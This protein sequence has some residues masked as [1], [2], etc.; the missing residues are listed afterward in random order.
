MS[1]WNI[2]RARAAYNI[3]H[4]GD[5]YFD[6]G[7]DGHA[8]ARPR[9]D[10]TQPAVDLHRLAG[11][12]RR[13]GLDLPVLVRFTDILGDRVQR[14]HGAFASA[15]AEHGYAGRYSPAYPIKTNQRRRVIEE[16]LRG[17]AIGL[18]AG[19]KPE[20]MAVLGLADTD[21]GLVICNGYKDRE[22][23]RLAL[24]GQQLGLR[25]YLVLEKP[26]ELDL[27]LDEARRLGVTPR[28]G[29]RVRLAS[30][31]RGKWHNTGGEKSK[32][33][34]TAA[35]V[36]DVVERLQAEGAGDTLQLLHV[37][38]GSQ[39][40]NLH[41][42]RNGVREAARFYADLRHLG[43]PIDCFDVGGGLG[44]DYEGT[45][46]RSACSTNYSI[47]EYAG[48]VI[49]A[50]AKTCNEAGLPHPELITESGR[51]LTAQH[52]MVICNIVDAT[53]PGGEEDLPPPLEDDPDVLHHLWRH[54][55]GVDHQAQLETYHETTHL[56]DEAQTLFN[57]GLLDLRQRALAERLTTQ[58]RHRL[59]ARLNPTVSAHRE[60]LDDL[61]E[62]L[63]DKLFCNLSLFRSLPDAWAIDQVFP[64]M[65][66]QRLDEEPTRR[67]VLED[68]TCD[69]DGRIDRF[70]DEGGL[71][72]TLRVH[73][74]QDG[75]D[76]L[77]GVF[78]VGA[79]QE[80]LGDLH[81]L[82][83]ETH[84]INVVTDGDGGYT[85]DAP[86]HGEGV[87]DVLRHVQFDP[88]ALRVT[89]R[90]RINAAPLDEAQRKAYLTELNASLTGYT[91]L[92]S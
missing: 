42:I 57:H 31:A 29:I 85:L 84:S 81:N 7:E 66:L 45:R 11:E 74:L 82:F 1:N 65:P 10:P 36:L 6:I 4:W 34:L 62:K 51:A 55:E 22:Y 27:I 91:Y 46:S 35:A 69:S 58:V 17:G 67:A 78:L 86:L 83:G 47:E 50:L 32:F 30:I 63:C 44:I 25:I 41:D 73:S 18:E 43:V 9:R 26:A 23:I 8:V 20:L 3:T 75:E 54:L 72:S 2:E 39:I 59:L 38:L 40:A 52:A 68:I 79:Y 5:G 87:D 28:L 76:Y 19:S 15:M 49:G 33:G 21:G 37:H 70:V 60:A 48:A 12:I 14:L 24:I 92:R 56:L 90:A 13:T 64:V 89:Y 16:I 61:R 80:I 53:T 77:L 88:D 71:E